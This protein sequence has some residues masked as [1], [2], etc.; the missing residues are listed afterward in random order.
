[1]NTWRDET[2]SR[3]PVGLGYTETSNI[4]DVV[5]NFCSPAYDFDRNSR[6]RYINSAIQD[7]V[8]SIRV[9]ITTSEVQ[10]ENIELMIQ[11]LRDS[12]ELGIDR[13]GSRGIEDYERDL[14]DVRDAMSRT[15]AEGRRG[16]AD[17]LKDVIQGQG[18]PLRLETIE[19]LED[20]D[21]DTNFVED[22]D[23]D[24]E[25]LRR[26]A[27]VYEEQRD[28]ESSVQPFAVLSG[29][30]DA[31]RSISSMPSSEEVARARQIIT[32][33]RQRRAALKARQAQ[34][35]D[36]AR[37]RPDA[38]VPSTDPASPGGGIERADKVAERW[39]RSHGRRPDGSARPTPT[40]QH[41]SPELG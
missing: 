36:A 32:P 28:A 24:L 26:E 8:Y 17:A 16:L 35:E 14:E 3:Y 40:D 6:I 2:S 41:D 22:F 38:P 9:G 30:V 27:T 1:M 23:L 21:R 34:K 25:R 20:F 12:Q 19:I 29:G 5:Q 11:S 31:G 13:S 39:L 33:D 4:K 15:S 37:R 10:I 18:I 7:E